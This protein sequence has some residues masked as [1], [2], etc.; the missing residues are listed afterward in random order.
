VGCVAEIVALVS[1]SHWVREAVKDRVKK[2]TVNRT[3]NVSAC[4]E[5]DVRGGL[6][7]REA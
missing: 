4:P 2:A 6:A 1:R 7:A 3:K 5:N